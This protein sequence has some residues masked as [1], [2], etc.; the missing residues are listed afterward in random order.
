MQREWKK[1]QRKGK[2]EEQ[3]NWN[4][5]RMEKETK[6]SKSRGTEKLE[7]YR[8]WKKKTNKGE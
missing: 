5:R 4:V 8:E 3:E 6:K 2:V 1:K 7:T